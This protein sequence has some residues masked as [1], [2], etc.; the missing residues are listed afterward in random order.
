MPADDDPDLDSLPP[1]LSR[2]EESS[3]LRRISS[4]QWHIRRILGS[5]R[6]VH[7][8]AAACAEQILWFSRELSEVADPALFRL[9]DFEVRRRLERVVRCYELEC[10]PEIKKR[11]YHAYPEYENTSRAIDQIPFTE[12]QWQ[13]FQRMIER[14]EPQGPSVKGIRDLEQRI[15]DSKKELLQGNLRQ[16][17]RLAR[18]QKDSG[19][20]AMDLIQLGNVGLVVAIG[21]FDYEHSRNFSVHAAWSIRRFMSG[22]IIDGSRGEG[23][24]E[25]LIQLPRGVQCVN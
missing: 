3:L 22:V 8:A 10:T 18:E 1:L 21:T 25:S 11:E 24:I 14:I 4:A 13:E 7:E 9:D 12:R 20:S 19:K 23:M 17:V 6:L 2:A 5:H 15:S 16:V